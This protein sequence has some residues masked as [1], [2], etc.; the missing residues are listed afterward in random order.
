MPDEMSV[1]VTWIFFENGLKKGVPPSFTLPAD[2][3]SSS[4]DPLPPFSL[5]TLTGAASPCQTSQGLVYG[6]S[7]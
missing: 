1:L 5:P 7:K 2:S 3:S 6:K 4:P